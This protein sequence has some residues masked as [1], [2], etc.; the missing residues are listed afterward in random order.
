MANIL[1]TNQEIDFFATPEDL[2]TSISTLDEVPTVPNSYDEV[3]TFLRNDGIF[4]VVFQKKGDGSLRDLWCTRNTHIIEKFVQD[5]E[6]AKQA[7]SAEQVEKDRSNGKITVFD[8]QKLEFRNF[9]LPT[10]IA[11]GAVAGDVVSMKSSEILDMV[12]DYEE[13]AIYTKEQTRKMQEKFA[14]AAEKAA[15]KG[16]KAI[17]FDM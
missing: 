16:G 15:A 17:E 6:H 11:I 2:L 8:M 13:L 7:V 10:A 4:R 12:P 1:S 5:K 14:K 9:L 3:M